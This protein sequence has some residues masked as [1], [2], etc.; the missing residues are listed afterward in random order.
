[1]PGPALSVRLRRWWRLFRT[2]QPRSIQVL[3]AIVAALLVADVAGLATTG[4]SSAPVARVAGVGGTGGDSGPGVGAVPGASA[5]TSS[6]A[7]GNGLTGGGGGLNGGSGPGSAS[8]GGPGSTAGSIGS[9]GPLLALGHGVTASSIKVVFPWPNL[10]PIGQ[11]VGLYGS[12][13]DDKLSIMAAV[14]AIN[15]AGG[16]NGRMIEPEMVG[17]NPLDQ[18]SMRADCIQWTQ[19]QHV[20]AVVDADAWHDDSQLCITQENRT[21]LI[22]SW[23]TVTDWTSRGNPN[24]WWTG[25]D[26]SEVLSNLVAWAVSGNQ[27]TPTTK[28]GVVAADRSAD[29]LSAGYLNRDLGAAGLKPTATGSM[30]FDLTSSAQSVAQAQDIVA[31]FR[32]KGVTTVIP[33]LPYNDFVYFLEAAQ[34]QGWVPHWLLSDYEF[35]AQAALGLIDPTSGGPFAKELNNAV[36]P[37]FFDLGNCDCDKPLPQGYDAFGQQCNA[38]FSKYSGATWRKTQQQ[39]GNTWSGYIETTGTAMTWCTNINLF[40][41]AAR[42]VSANQLTQTAFDQAM[43]GLTHFAGQLAPDYQY[44]G[45]RRA[46]PHEFRVVQEHV[47]SDGK[48]PQKVTGGSQGDCWLIQQDFRPELSV[49]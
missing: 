20:F 5:S 23:T 9:A 22:S 27:L 1:M 10:G 2:Q 19:D 49:P 13:E 34:Q 26:V 40:A 3:V 44:G 30:H 24:L 14:D 11:A 45:T 25:P 42:A 39:Q 8:S 46:G 29:T 47:N 15:A 16:I 18:A 4:S 17:F 36:N 48:C 7:T 28:F 35:E 12:S 32:S 38:N 43:E 33:L 31:Q 41:A 37:T 21:P 6:G